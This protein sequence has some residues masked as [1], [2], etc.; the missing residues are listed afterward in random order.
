MQDAVHADLLEHLRHE[1]ESAHRNPSRN[2]QHLM[3]RQM[4]AQALAHQRG[5]VGHVII[6][7]AL[8]A[9]LAQRGAHGVG[10]GAPHLVRL[11]RIAWFDQFVARGDH[12]DRRLAAHAHASHARRSRH[13][14]LRRMQYETGRQQQRALGAIA[15]ASVYVVPGR[16]THCVAQ[17]E[18]AILALEQLDRD[19]AVTGA[20]QDRPRHDFDAMLEGGQLRGRIP[21]C[22]GGLDPEAP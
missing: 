22:L 9:A 16:G 5:V 7:H 18:M 20:G 14:D 6:G 13:C 12:D 8:E 17:R 11:D 21:C 1:I 2:D 3:G 15:G 19:D 4:H 10:V